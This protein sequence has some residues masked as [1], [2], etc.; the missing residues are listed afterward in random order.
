[1]IGNIA[2]NLTGDGTLL[3]LTRLT[4]LFAY[5]ALSVVL[6]PYLTNIGLSDSKTVCS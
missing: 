5:G 2:S 4:R 1:M 6:L 3:F